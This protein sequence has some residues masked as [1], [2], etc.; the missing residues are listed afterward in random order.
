MLKSI[1]NL[2][3]AKQLTSTDLRRISGKGNPPSLCYCESLGFEVD[4][5]Y[6]DHICPLDN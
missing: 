2:E 6:Y 3:G 1:L 5:N 4:C